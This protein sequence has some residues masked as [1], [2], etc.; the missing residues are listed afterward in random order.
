MVTGPMLLVIFFAALTV[1]LVLI[2]VFKANPFLALLGTGILTAFAA[3][4]PAS[5]IGDIVATGFGG[6]LRG[7]GIVVGLGIILGRL[8]AEAHA[9]DQIAQST[10]NTVGEKR[11]PLAL[12]LSGFVVSI[13]VFQDAA[14]VILMP[15]ARRLSRITKFSFLTFVTALGVSTIVTHALVIPTPGPIAVA[16]NMGVDFGVFIIYALIVAIPAALVASVFYA[17]T[18]KNVAPT[19]TTEMEQI[20]ASEEEAAKSE[21]TKGRPSGA[22][23]FGVLLLPIVLILVG[24]IAT[25]L[26]PKTGFAAQFFGFIGDKNMALFIGVLFA[27]YALKRYI[28]TSITSVIVESAAAAGMI[29]LITGAGGGFGRVITQSGIGD[30]LVETMSGLQITPVL[31]AFILSQLLRLG[32]G[33]TTVALITTSSILGPV[34]MQFGASPVL[35]GLAACAGGIGLSM[36]N[37]SGFWVVSRFSGISVPNTLR[38]WTAGGTIAGVTALAMVLILNAFS[39]VLPG[40]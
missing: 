29:F 6:T 35:V 2:V 38:T 4:F 15:L 10:L 16:G 34:A 24:S 11:S 23:S 30:Y 40:L 13:P 3:G 12:A 32:Q 18:L 33:S 17:S 1:L 27:I 31:L 39:G 26:L 28:S 22:L 8:L 7:I 9:T 19:L 21:D 36:P 5:E 14:F 25:F 37:D 20:M